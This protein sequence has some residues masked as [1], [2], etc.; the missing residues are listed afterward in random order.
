[1]YAIIEDSGSQIIVRE[2]DVIRVASRDIDS[3]ESNPPITFD[4]VLFVG[5]ESGEGESRIGAP[6]VEGAK[7]LGELSKADRT[8]KVSVIKFKRRK[9]YRRR[10]SHRQD[11]LEVKITQIQA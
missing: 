11:Y 7:V 8:D 2:G 10:K 6:V 4:R 5:D 3:S 1:M 9:N